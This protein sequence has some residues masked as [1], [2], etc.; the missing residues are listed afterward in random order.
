MCEGKAVLGHQAVCERVQRTGQTLCARYSCAVSFCTRE[1]LVAHVDTMPE[2]KY[3]CASSADYA[4]VGL[5]RASA[6]M[7][8]CGRGSRQSVLHQDIPWPQV[9]Y[10]FAVARCLLVVSFI[11]SSRCMRRGGVDQLPREVCTWPERSSV[12]TTFVC[13]PSTL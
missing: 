12:V 10:S 3:I 2:F 7:R 4:R 11:Q 1:F 13:A 9:L 5:T 8:E 6:S